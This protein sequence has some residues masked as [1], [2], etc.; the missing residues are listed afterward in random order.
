MGRNGCFHVYNKTFIIF[1]EFE[2]E[3]SPQLPSLVGKILRE[4]LE[5]ILLLALY[6]SL[7]DL[8]YTFELQFWNWKIILYIF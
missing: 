3:T 4:V 5:V 1:N 7:V 6:I 2:K 8:C